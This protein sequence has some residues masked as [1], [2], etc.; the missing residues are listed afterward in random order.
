MHV[1]STQKRKRSY[2][3]FKHHLF[4]FTSIYFF[5]VPSGVPFMATSLS[6]RK[7]FH[8]YSKSHGILGSC[9]CENK[10]LLPKQFQIDWFN[11]CSKCIIYNYWFCTSQVFYVQV[12]DRYKVK[13]Y[14]KY[15]RDVNNSLSNSQ[16]LQFL[17]VQCKCRTMNFE[18]SLC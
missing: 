6:K 5:V 1:V 3:V 10:W 8:F 18:S 13:S 2:Q 17:M 9:L 7:N 14:T 15:I 4:F 11:Y 16:N 12:S